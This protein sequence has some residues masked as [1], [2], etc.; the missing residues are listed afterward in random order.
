M[1]I[2]VHI[3]SNNGPADMSNIL[4][5]LWQL[6]KKLCKFQELTTK[7]YLLQLK[8]FCI[9]C[10]ISTLW[11]TPCPWEWAHSTLDGPTKLV[12]PE[13]VFLWKK[14][15]LVFFNEK[16]CYYVNESHQLEEKMKTCTNWV[17]S[18]ASSRRVQWAILGRVFTVVLD[19]TCSLPYTVFYTYS[20]N[21][22]F[23]FRFF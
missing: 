9:P 15:I 10:L 20:N 23:L 18:V 3:K 12:S 1:C 14:G 17:Q 7:I 4:I 2:S 6:L 19:P 11:S 16:Y 5:T 21:C 22:S 8:V 13:L